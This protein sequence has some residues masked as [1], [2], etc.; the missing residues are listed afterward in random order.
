MSSP[1][2]R[3]KRERDA[4][5]RERGMSRIPGSPSRRFWIYLIPGLLML[6][7]I[8]VIPAVWNIYLSFTNYRGIKP[9]VWTGMTN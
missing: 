1:T 2:N 4:A 9:P 6:L 7:W 5:K 3:T 8:I